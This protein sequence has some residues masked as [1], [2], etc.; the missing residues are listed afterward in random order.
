MAL[1]ASLYKINDDPRMIDKTLGTA[2]KVYN[3][4]DPS[5]TLTPLEPIDTLAPRLIVEY[6][7]SIVG[8]NYIYIADWDKYYYITNVDLTTAQRIIF[9]CKVDVLY[10]YKDEIKN[11]T[12]IK[13]RGSSYPGNQYI[14][15]PQVLSYMEQ[16]T[17]TF[18]GQLRGWNTSTTMDFNT[19]YLTLMG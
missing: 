3:A 14:P 10:T 6:D 13:E 7:Q 19:I 9:Q 1:S 18:T 8:C 12:A 5:N 4:S 2:T 15:D 11:L 16:G 17:Q